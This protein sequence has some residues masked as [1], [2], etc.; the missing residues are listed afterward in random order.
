M[1]SFSFGIHENRTGRIF[2][3]A[4]A[5]GNLRFNPFLQNIEDSL[6]GKCD[7]QISNGKIANTG[8]QDQLG[9][10][11]DPL[12][13]KLKDLE[14]NTISGSITIS[15]KSYRF[16]PLVFTS[17]DIRL[18]AEGSVTNKDTLDSKITLE[19][20]NTFIQDLTNP[21]AMLAL[22]RYKK[23]KWYTRHFAIKGNIS[24]GKYDP[25]DMDQ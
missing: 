22:N 2:G 16:N 1:R 15:G 17:P 20:D 14:F 8:I 5:R 10:F 24:E 23:G 25:Q 6:Q 12:K 19:F 4:K 7:F 9:I 13:Y 3:N 18:M 11:L 21:A